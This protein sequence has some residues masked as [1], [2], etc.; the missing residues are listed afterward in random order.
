M[1]RK[2]KYS[3]GVVFGHTIFIDVKASDIDEARDKAE[4]EASKI[5]KNLLDDGMF[6]MKDFDYEAFRN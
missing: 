1:S 2:K 3:M 6:G 5:F 4:Y